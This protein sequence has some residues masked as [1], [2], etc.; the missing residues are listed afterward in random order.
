MTD[1]KCL[2]SDSQLTQ[3]AVDAERE[4]IFAVIEAYFKWQI[5]H[6]IEGDKEYTSKEI[7]EVLLPEF[8]EELKSRIQGGI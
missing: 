5:A 4:R 6:A 7:G 1:C 8:I 3:F 2:D